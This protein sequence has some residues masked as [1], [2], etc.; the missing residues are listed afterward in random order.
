MSGRTGMRRA[1][2]L[3]AMTH[4][5]Q[6]AYRI[7]RTAGLKDA[8]VAGVLDQLSRINVAVQD[9]HGRWLLC[10]GGHVENALHEARELLATAEVG[11]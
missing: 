4:D 3:A 9:I 6:T 8:A 5:G 11:A 10:R 7:A 1:R 2:V